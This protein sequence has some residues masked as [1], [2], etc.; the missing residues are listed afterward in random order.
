MGVG[1]GEIPAMGK[2]NDRKTV[3]VFDLNNTL[4]SPER[5]MSP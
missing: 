3:Q 5:G 1:Y 2:R 4:F